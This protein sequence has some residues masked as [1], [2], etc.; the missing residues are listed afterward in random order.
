ENPTPSQVQVEDPYRGSARVGDVGV[1][2]GPL[3]PAGKALFGNQLVDVVTQ[4]E[5]LAPGTEVE[6]IEHRGNRV[7]VRARPS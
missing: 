1:A 6:V 5:F 7:V 4:G 2:Q 3:R